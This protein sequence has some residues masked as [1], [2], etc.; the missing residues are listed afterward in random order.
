MRPKAGVEEQIVTDA[1][2]YIQFGLKI[3]TLLRSIE[4]IRRVADDC[5]FG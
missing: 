5:G 4:Q 3:K 1:A 2:Q